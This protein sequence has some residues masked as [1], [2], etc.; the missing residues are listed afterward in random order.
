MALIE[1]AIVARMQGFAGL[2]VLVGTAPNDRIYPVRL[3]QGVTFPAISY[4]RI[5]GQRT[6]AISGVSALARPRFQISCWGSDYG[7]VKA[8]AEQVRKCFE[9]FSGTMGAGISAQSMVDDDH[10]EYDPETQIYHVPVDIFVWFEE[11]NP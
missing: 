1:E 11:N 10:D 8:V 7:S 9:G 5:S 6:H 3:P 4:Q 2:T